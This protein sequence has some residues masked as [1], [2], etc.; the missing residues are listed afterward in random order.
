[1]RTDFQIVIPGRPPGPAQRAPLCRPDGRLREAEANPESRAHAPP[2]GRLDSGFAAEPVIG[3][4]KGRTR[5]RRPGMTPKGCAQ[6]ASSVTGRT[7]LGARCKVD[8]R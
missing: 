3:P 8:L 6:H 5:W 4:A 1:M 7:S 2:I